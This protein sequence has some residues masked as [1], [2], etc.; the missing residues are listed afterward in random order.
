MLKKVYN[1]PACVI[2]KS[3]VV[4]DLHIGIEKE[5]SKHGARIPVAI[6][7]MLQEL[8]Q[9]IKQT[10]AKDI[11]ILGD[12]KHNIYG[13]TIEERNA[14]KEFV[15]K[16]PVPVKLIKG[17]HDGRIEEW[18]DIQVY[19]ATGFKKGEYWLLHGH[20]KP[21]AEAEPPFIMSHVHPA[22]WFE[23]NLGGRIIEKVWVEQEDLII[24]PSFNPLIRG[25]NIKQGIIGPMKK[26][27]DPKK[28]RISL[29]D[30]VE[31]KP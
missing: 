15:K 9:L 21:P 12:L 25:A 6:N 11:I 24:M 18:L 16:I 10:K 26:Y 8:I 27:Y 28:A 17:N 31:V 4:A 5:L 3:L 29:L 30:G 1:K 7:P 23:D 14:L 22:V 20:A 19:P 13:A 2:Q